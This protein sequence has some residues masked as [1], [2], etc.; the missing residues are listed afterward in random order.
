MPCEVLSPHGHRR[1]PASRHGPVGAHLP[2]F[3]DVVS[4]G[5]MQL[6]GKEASA[7]HGLGSLQNMLLVIVCSAAN[8]G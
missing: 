1:R 4:M 2:L 7:V 8:G 6:V 3:N 5:A